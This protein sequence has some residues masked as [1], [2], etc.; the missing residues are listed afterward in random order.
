[1]KLILKEFIN[2]N[3]SPPCR[4][5]CSYFITTFLFWEYEETEPSYWCKENFRECVMCLLSEFCECVSMRSLR[6]YFIPR[7]N[8]LSMKMTDEAQIELLRIF[9]IILHSDICIFKECKSLKEDWV[10]CLHLD[11]DKIDVT[12]IVKKNVLRNDI[13]KMKVV[14]ELPLWVLKHH[15][16]H[17][18]VDLITFA[19]QF[20]N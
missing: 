10:Q 8:L 7:F 17:E 9:D 5:L 3:C 11:A 4:V 16:N 18:C 14:E 12:V 6:H 2:P 20:I 15:S 13:G 19:S 1:M